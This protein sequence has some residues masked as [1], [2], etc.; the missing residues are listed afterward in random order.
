MEIRISNSNQ[1]L[2]YRLNIL[3]ILGSVISNA[4]R[5]PHAPEFSSTFS[6]IAAG[7]EKVE[8][9]SISLFLYKI[10]ILITFNDYPLPGIPNVSFFPNIISCWGGIWS[11]L[12]MHLYSCIHSVESLLQLSINLREIIKKERINIRTPVN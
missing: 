10:L 11:R 12:L 8:I 2:S 1:N 4:C 5:C 3:H 6:R 9:F 7:N